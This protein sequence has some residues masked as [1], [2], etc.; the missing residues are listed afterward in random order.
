LYGEATQ[1]GAQ[2]LL[3]DRV[4][5]VHAQAASA[6]ITGTDPGSSPGRAA[7]LR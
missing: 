1:F 2:D 4:A 5:G 3:G 6:Q 7:V